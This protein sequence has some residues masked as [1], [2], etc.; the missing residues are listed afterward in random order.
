MM[1]ERMSSFFIIIDLPNPPMTTCKNC[2]NLFEGKYCPNCAQ[3][4]DTHRLT[5]AHFGH[6]FLHALTHTDKGIL[7]LIKE[8]TRRPG[9]VAL[10][11][12]AGK[13]KK[14]FSPITYL[15]IILAIQIYAVKKTDFYG[16]FTSTL[17][18]YTQ[19]IIAKNKNAKR[20][21]ENLDKSIKETKKQVSLTSENAKLITFIYIPI[22]ALLTWLFFY[23]S[24]NNY[25]ENLVF[26]VLLNAQMAFF[27]LIICIIPV[28]IKP[29][30]VVLVMYL[31]LLVNVIYSLIAY[32]QF[33]KQ[34][35]RWILLKGITVQLIYFAII[36]F[37]MQFYVNYFG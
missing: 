36:T 3:K 19:Q 15:L 21:L 1:S 16:K 24:G 28:L 20:D 6:E 27:F 9:K 33:F 12:N 17:E 5:L 26:N 10:E 29:G 25:T 35:W 37:S 8:L 30:S 18:Q 31:S 34:K 11:Y 23:R 7:F 13:R 32:K 2:E 22:L 14:Y 4:A